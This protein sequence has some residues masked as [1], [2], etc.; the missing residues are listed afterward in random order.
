MV[1]FGM[2][3]ESE[4]RCEQ[5]STIWGLVHDYTGFC[6]P[7]AFSLTLVPGNMVNKV[8]DDIFVA[9]HPEKSAEDKVLHVRQGLNT[10]ITELC[11]LLAT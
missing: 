11:L 5:M 10:N 6:Q 2:S 9:K 3:D 7:L 4:L 8:S 1:W